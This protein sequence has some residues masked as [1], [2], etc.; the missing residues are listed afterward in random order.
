[1]KTDDLLSLC[2]PRAKNCPDIT[3]KAG[4]QWAL[5]EF[6]QRSWYYQRTLNISV[7]G[8]DVDLSNTLDDAQIIAVADV[9]CDGFALQPRENWAES[10]RY[11]TGGGPR[12]WS[13]TPPA[14]LSVLP[15]VPQEVEVQVRLVLQPENGIVPDDIY[16]NF[17]L[18][19]VDGALFWIL[20]TPEEVWTNPQLASFH[21]QRFAIGINT[22]KRKQIN[23]EMP[24]DW[25]AQ[26]RAFA[27]GSGHRR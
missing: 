27:V 13:F 20:S 22:A 10:G 8:V 12:A 1:M 19:I 16:R 2:R 23:G 4:L 5:I 21:M 7:R 17:R 15:D 25:R 9:A 18:N 14:M 26:P 24:R 3:L 11:A 6:C